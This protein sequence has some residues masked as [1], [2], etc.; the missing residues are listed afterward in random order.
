MFQ[1]PPAHLRRF[2][3]IV[4]HDYGSEKGLEGWICVP[5]PKKR[6]NSAKRFILTKPAW[7]SEENLPRAPSLKGLEIWPYKSWEPL[8]YATLGDQL[9]CFKHLKKGPRAAKELCYTL[10]T[11]MFGI[12]AQVYDF[13]FQESTGECVM[14][15][16]FL[17]G[18]DIDY[19][20]QRQFAHRMDLMLDRAVSLTRIAH[21]DVH[22]GN[23]MLHNGGLKVIDWESG[24][25]VPETGERELP[26]E[27]KEISEYGSDDDNDSS[28]VEEV[29]DVS[30]EKQRQYEDM[31][32]LYPPNY[33]KV[34]LDKSVPVSYDQKASRTKK[35][36]F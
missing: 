21:R 18:G 30:K 2:Y 5:L 15:M 23:F 22:G 27:D 19:K 29:L 14:L 24:F 28:V 3:K 36:E 35:I 31:S 33:R 26:S 7:F 25:A 12:G 6:A 17:S 11:S 1:K 8:G 13:W 16:E 9:L 20:K 10:L 34:R 32:R 4:R